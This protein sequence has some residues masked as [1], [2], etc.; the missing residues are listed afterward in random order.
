VPLT[1]FFRPGG[2]LSNLHYGVIDERTLVLQ[3][4][5]LVNG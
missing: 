4:D 2:E 1:F 3:I 5:E